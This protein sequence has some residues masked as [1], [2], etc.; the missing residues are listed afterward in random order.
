MAFGITATQLTNTEDLHQ[1]TTGHSSH[2]LSEESIWAISHH[3]H[4]SASN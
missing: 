4:V 2:L 1:S 3:H